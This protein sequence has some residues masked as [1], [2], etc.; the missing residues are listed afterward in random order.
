[1]FTEAE[2]IKI[3]RHDLSERKLPRPP[4][5]TAFQSPNIRPR[6]SAPGNFAPTALLSSQKGMSIPAIAGAIERTA[7][8]LR[9]IPRRTTTKSETLTRAQLEDLVFCRV[10]LPFSLSGYELN[11][12]IAA[13]V[14]T[15]NMEQW[16]RTL[17]RFRYRSEVAI[18]TAERIASQIHAMS[19]DA[20]W[21]LH[22]TDWDM[23]AFAYHYLL[24]QSILPNR[25]HQ[26]PKCFDKNLG[27]ELSDKLIEKRGDFLSQFHPEK[28]RAQQERISIA[29]AQML[30][31]WRNFYQPHVWALILQYKVLNNLIAV[32]W[33]R[34]PEKE[35]ASPELRK[36][37]DTLKFV[38]SLESYAD[39]FPA[40]VA[41]RFNLLALASQFGQEELYRT[42]FL[43]LCTA[44][45][46][47]YDLEF[48]EKHPDADGDLDKFL[49]YWAE[50]GEDC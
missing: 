44:D 42:R 14:R 5:A 21:T 29:L 17:H 41:P 4:L 12:Q 40:E 49:S 15:S 30:D 22:D 27:R 19:T 25:F 48:L 36:Y 13:V 47:F 37:I 35:R 9:A 50:H 23:V 46:R 2:S 18:S 16:W 26:D 33:E 24:L 31:N 28:T 38:A 8:Q 45:S 20:A 1:M 3:L 32:A 43:D 7:D 11:S 39:H 10:R 6:S 34:A